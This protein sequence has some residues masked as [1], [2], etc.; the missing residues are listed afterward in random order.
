MKKYHEMTPDEKYC[1]G[2]AAALLASIPNIISDND[3]ALAELMQAAYDKEFE[4]FKRQKVRREFEAFKH[5]LAGEDIEAFILRVKGVEFEDYLLRFTVAALASLEQEYIRVERHK[6]TA[7]DLIQHDTNSTKVDRYLHFLDTKEKEAATITKP[8]EK[9]PWQS[10]ERVY[11]FIIAEAH[12]KRKINVFKMGKNE[13]KAYAQSLMAN[14]AA[15]AKYPMLKAINAQTLYLMV[16]CKS[17]AVGAEPNYID[18]EMQLAKIHRE[19][20]DFAME[21]YPYYFPV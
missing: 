17:K 13:F 6:L 8:L 15:R 20:S 10:L 11:S 7:C 3:P 12:N 2:Y 5:Q 4:A 16:K 19:D 18:K 9:Q 1:Y 21:I 14:E